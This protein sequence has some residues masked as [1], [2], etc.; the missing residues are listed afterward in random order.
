M[1]RKTKTKKRGRKAVKP[2][3]WEVLHEDVGT[4]SED[5]CK[6][7]LNLALVALL[8]V[9]VVPHI[10][11]VSIVRAQENHMTEQLVYESMIDYD[12][13]GWLA[14]EYTHVEP[15][16]AGAMTGDISQERVDSSQE[17][18]VSS[19]AEKLVQTAQVLD[20][21]ITG[22]LTG[23]TM[24]V[25]DISEQVQPIV[26]FYQPGLEATWNAWLELMVDPKL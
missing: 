25:L 5:F 9:W 1:A 7:V 20:Q 4:C 23:A 21:K 14:S 19:G 18:V 17:T 8:I 22:P 6:A 15:R 2:S 10:D 16:V 12:S 11:G 26:D 24:Q 3:V 13:N